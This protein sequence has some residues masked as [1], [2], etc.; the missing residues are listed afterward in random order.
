[1]EYSKEK[2]RKKRTNITDIEASLK[3]C[4]ENCM[5]CPSPEN[6]QQLQKLKVEYENL[7]ENLAQ[8]TIIQSRATWYEK[9]DKC[10]K[11]FLNL[12]AHKKTKSSVHKAF[13]KEHTVTDPKNVI[14]EIEKFYSAR[15]S[16]NT[17]TH[18]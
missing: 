14:H 3:A 18:C 1:M 6:L 10:N 12:E 7:Y 11:Y 13:K 9:G 4:K 16:K 2:A 8:C 15:E 17:Q 5:E